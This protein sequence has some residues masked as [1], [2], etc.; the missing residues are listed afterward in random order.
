MLTYHIFKTELTQLQ[1]WT[2]TSSILRYQIF[3]IDLPHLQYWTSNAPSLLNFT[4]SVLSYL[5]YWDTKFQYWPTTSSILNFQRTFLTELHIF[6]IELSSI[7]R[8][9]ISILTYHIFNTELPTHLPYWTSHLQY[10]ATTFSILNYHIFYTDLSR[11]LYRYWII[12]YA[13]LSY[14]ISKSEFPQ[15]RCLRMDVWAKSVCASKLSLL[16]P[17]L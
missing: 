15:S 12:T 1:Y 2:T 13:I 9:Q 16:C 14:H 4:S 5:Q 17:C 10:W 11:L 7:L 6:S 3:N 8:Y